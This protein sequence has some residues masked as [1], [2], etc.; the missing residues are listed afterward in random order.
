MTKKHTFIENGFVFLAFAALFAAIFALLAFA[1]ARSAHALNVQPQSGTNECAEC[2]SQTV[3]LWLVSTHG[4][5]P[6]NCDTCHVLL[7]GEGEAHPELNYST[8]R[9]DATCGTCHV[10]I[11]NEWYGGRHG[12]FDMNCATCHE[13]HSQRQKLT[14]EN[15]TTCEACHRPQVEAGHGSTHTAAGADCTTCHIGNESGHGFSVTLSTCNACHSDIHEA[16]QMAVAGLVGAEI[17]QP[18]EE[19]AEAVETNQPEARGGINLPSWLLLL[20]GLLIGGVVVWVLIGK[21][22]GTPTEDDES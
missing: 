3:D 8:E 10:E 9:E 11:K 15:E 22:P 18:E 21:D 14:G 6:I 19:T 17:P 12:L 4:S 20:A 2:H 16:S 13:P 1:P 5:V 7:P